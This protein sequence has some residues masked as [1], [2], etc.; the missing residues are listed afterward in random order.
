MGTD[1][2]RTINGEPLVLTDSNFATHKISSGVCAFDGHLRCTLLA[3]W[4]WIWPRGCFAVLQVQVRKANEWTGSYEDL[5]VDKV[6]KTSEEEKL[7][8]NEE[9]ASLAALDELTR[10][11]LDRQMWRG[12]M[13]IKA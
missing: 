1:L 6:M 7:A 2:W 9:E 12:E 13:A 10:K 3:L 11:E 8:A 5:G 4:Q